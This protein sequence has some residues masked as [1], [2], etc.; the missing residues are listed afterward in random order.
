MKTFIVD[1]GEDSQGGRFALVQSSCL[2]GALRTADDVGSPFKIAELKI[3]SIRHVGR[4][5]EISNDPF[6]GPKI[7]EGLNWVE[8]GCVFLSIYNNAQGK[9]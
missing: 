4:Y 2:E 5:I 8:S 6:Y 7:E 9:F 1:Y 3:K